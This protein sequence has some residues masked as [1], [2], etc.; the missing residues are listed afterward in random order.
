[1]YRRRSKNGIE[2]LHKIGDDVSR[3]ITGPNLSRLSSDYQ[4]TFH[5]LP[6]HYP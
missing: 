2:G 1:M 5:T 3:D 4:D 6:D